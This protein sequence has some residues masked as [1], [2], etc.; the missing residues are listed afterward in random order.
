MASDTATGVDKSPQPVLEADFT[1]IEQTRD[2]SVSRDE[3][4]D[5]LWQMVQG[6]LSDDEKRSRLVAQCPEAAPLTLERA[7]REESEVIHQQGGVW[8]M[9]VAFGEPRTPDRDF[10]MNREISDW[11]DETEPDTV[12]IVYRTPDGEVESVTGEASH[13]SGVAI[14]YKV[15]VTKGKDA[16][17]VPQ[18]GEVTA[19]YESEDWQE[20]HYLGSAIR[21]E[22][23]SNK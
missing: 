18:S 3:A 4:E 22:V 5:M 16:Y 9:K 6:D 23:N 19:R 11:D 12:T 13:G 7:H 2:E 17:D 8:A 14:D 21:V 1:D 15:G 20:E 10:E